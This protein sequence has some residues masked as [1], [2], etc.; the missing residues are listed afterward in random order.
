MTCMTEEQLK[1][2]HEDIE[3]GRVM[4]V[5]M[6]H[7]RDIY[8]VMVWMYD[9]L[10]GNAAESMELKH[11]RAMR[12]IVDLTFKPNKRPPKKWNPDD[13]AYRVGQKPNKEM[14]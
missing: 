1:D 12:D 13:P 3:K 10:E 11:A 8:D 4:I 7:Y 2:L 9:Q 5:S 14:T 6:D